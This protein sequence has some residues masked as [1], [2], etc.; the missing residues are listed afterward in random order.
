MVG[1]VGNAVIAECKPYPDVFLAT[2]EVRH[3]RA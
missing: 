1:F 2:A 3:P